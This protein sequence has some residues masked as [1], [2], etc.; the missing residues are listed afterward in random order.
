MNRLSEEEKWIIQKKSM[1]AL[2]KSSAIHCYASFFTPSLFYE[3]GLAITEPI[4]KEQRENDAT[5]LIKKIELYTVSKQ[6]PIKYV[7]FIV[8]V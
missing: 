1:I 4:L 8:C 3:M 7:T 2:I 6:L 5:E